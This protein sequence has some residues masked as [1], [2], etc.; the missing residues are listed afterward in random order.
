[1]LA[2]IQPWAGRTRNHNVIRVH[3][4]PCPAPFNT[5]AATSRLNFKARASLLF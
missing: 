3:N 1:M 2:I 5:K 4:S